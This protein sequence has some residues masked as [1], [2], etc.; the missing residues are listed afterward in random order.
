MAEQIRELLLASRD[1][2]VCE[3]TELLLIFAARAQ[4]VQAKIEPALRQGQWVLS[5]RFIDATYAYQGG[6]RQLS[7][8][9]ITQ[10]ASLVIPD[11]QPDL[12]IVLDLPV[13]LGLERAQRRGSLDRFETET[14]AFFNRVRECYLQR[15]AADPQRYCVVDAA[16]SLA[17]VQCQIQQ[18]LSERIGLA[19]N[20]E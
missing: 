10:L 12:V 4:H 2:T 19:V 9:H 3:L 5:D 20:A 17:A 13:E 15:A 7:S 16:Q 18:A 14:V 6:G 8:R 11:T 1:E